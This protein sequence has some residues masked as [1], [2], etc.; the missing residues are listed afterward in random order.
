[1]VGAGG[2]V[3]APEGAPGPVAA[4]DPELDDQVAL[5]DNEQFPPAERLEFA[6][7]GDPGGLLTACRQ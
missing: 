5:G 6:P 1:V 3:E 2:H 4:P 7:L